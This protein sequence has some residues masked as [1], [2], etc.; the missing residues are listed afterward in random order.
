M[1]RQIISEQATIEAQLA[2]LHHR[3][4]ALEIE[5]CVTVGLTTT[6][7]HVKL[8]EVTCPNHAYPV[9]NK[10]KECTMMKNFMASRALSMGKKPE[11]EPG[12]KA[13][14]PFPGEEV[15]MS[16]YGGPV[17]HESRRKLKLTSREVNTVNPATPEYLRWSKSL[18][19]F[20]WLDHLDWVLKPRRFP[21][22]VDSLVRMTWLT[23]ALMDGGSNLNL[24]YLDTFEGLGLGQDMPK[25]SL[26]PFYEVV[27]S[28]QP[29]PL[30]QISLPVTF[31]DVNNYRTKMLAFEV[32]DCSRPYHVILGRQCYVKFMAI[33]N[34]TYLKL[35]I[36]RPADI[37]TIE[38]K[39]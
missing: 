17:P 2:K 3:K 23:K 16:I 32:V 12:G 21:L 35:K 36:P 37:N 13:V 27:S 31:G 25:T 38:A 39:A 20:D 22:I 14:T 11:G 5:Q 33:T 18:I 29:I 9:R 10:L 1:V 4:S 6:I 34:Y 28:K 8:L 24:M 19:T 7:N 26:H 15:V 30:E